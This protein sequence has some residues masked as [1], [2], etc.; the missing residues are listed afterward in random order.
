MAHLE[1][2][3]LKPNISRTEKVVIEGLDFIHFWLKKE[4][5]DV[6]EAMV[7]YKEHR[8]SLIIKEK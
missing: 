6:F 7:L 8:A 2:I 3:K 5:L 4:N 1:T